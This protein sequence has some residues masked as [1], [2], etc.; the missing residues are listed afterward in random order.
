MTPRLNATRNRPSRPVWTSSGTTSDLWRADPTRV[1]WAQAS[2]EFNDLV[3]VLINDRD[4]VTGPVPGTTENF[5]AGFEKGYAAALRLVRSLAM[6]LSPEPPPA[7][8]QTYQPDP[9]NVTDL[10]LD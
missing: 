3:N 8:A 6:G 5:A 7:P 4:M 2:R 1:G 10:P 9:D